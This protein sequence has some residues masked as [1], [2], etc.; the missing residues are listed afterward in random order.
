MSD[1]LHSPVWFVVRPLR[2]PCTGDGDCVSDDGA[3]LPMTIF[4][5]KLSKLLDCAEEIIDRSVMRCRSNFEMLFDCEQAEDAYRSKKEHGKG[6]KKAKLKSP[7]AE[8]WQI[9]MIRMNR[10]SRGVSNRLLR[11]ALQTFPEAMLE[12][13]QNDD[14]SETV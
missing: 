3:Q 13:E 10:R 9:Q 14:S 6:R 12:A 4:K 7:D 11:L 2:K 1:C 5:Q 8:M